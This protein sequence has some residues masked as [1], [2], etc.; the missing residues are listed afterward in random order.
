MASVLRRQT[1]VDV[2][3]RTAVVQTQLE[4]FVAETLCFAVERFAD[5]RT[6]TIFNCTR[7]NIH[8]RFS[9][10]SQRPASQ[11]VTFTSNTAI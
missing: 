11:F 10:R 5:M 6:S 2:D 3:A 9:V 4:T 1:L 7:I 8:T